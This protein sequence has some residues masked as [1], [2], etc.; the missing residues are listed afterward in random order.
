[1]LT[2]A[3]ILTRSPCEVTLKRT[4]GEILPSITSSCVRKYS[5]PPTCDQQMIVFFLIEV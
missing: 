2:Y 1:M 3:A 5:P 4:K